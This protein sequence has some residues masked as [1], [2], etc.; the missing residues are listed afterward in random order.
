MV[1]NRR[2]SYIAD[3]STKFLWNICFSLLVWEKLGPTWF[4]TSEAFYHH[5]NLGFL[6]YLDGGKLPF[7][8]YTGQTKVNIGKYMQTKSSYFGQMQLFCLKSFS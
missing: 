7:D 4:W 5:L 2:N 3:K 1:E 6:Q 8:P